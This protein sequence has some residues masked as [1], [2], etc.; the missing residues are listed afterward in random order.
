VATIEQANQGMEVLFND[1]S[2]YEWS[3][4]IIQ[5]LISYVDGIGLNFIMAITINQFKL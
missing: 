5:A 2:K 3:R 1:A 4:I